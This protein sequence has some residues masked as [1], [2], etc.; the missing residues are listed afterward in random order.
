MTRGYIVILEGKK[1]KRV[2]YSNSDSYFCTE[3]TLPAG[4]VLK[5]MIQE[6]V[7]AELNKRLDKQVEAGHFEEEDFFK[8]N[9]EYKF[10]I[11]TKENEEDF[12][13]DYVY[14]YNVKTKKLTVYY[15]GKKKIQFSK[16][17]VDY[18]KYLFEKDTFKEAFSYNEDTLMYEN[19]YYK[20]FISFMKEKKSITE[21][22]SLARELIAKHN[23]SINYYSVADCFGKYHYKKTVNIHDNKGKVIHSFEFCVA[24]IDSYSCFDNSEPPKY[25]QMNIQLPYIRSNIF[26][27]YLKPN[28]FRPTYYSEKT[29]KKAFIEYLKDEKVQEELI[30]AVPLYKIYEK[31]NKDFLTLWE[32]IKGMQN[33]EKLL[34]VL[35]E[36]RESFIIELNKALKPFE[37]DTFSNMLRK[38]GNIFSADKVRDKLLDKWDN[39]IRHCKTH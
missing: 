29:L 25:Y 4:L 21:I 19:D 39:T 15:F 27:T 20:P 23:I 35:N 28:K 22:D 10:Y 36:E 31:Y 30:K 11:K 3:E 18:M 1:I 32:N 7:L 17:D 13:V 33:K 16:N 6:D 34:E 38:N 14:E 24:P 9:D 26:Y 8:N 12:F 5:A 37:K 2:V